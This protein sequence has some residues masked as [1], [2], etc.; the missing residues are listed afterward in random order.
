MNLGFRR[1]EDKNWEVWILGSS[2]QSVQV[3]IVSDAGWFRPAAG[4]TFHACSMGGIYHHTLLCGGNKI[5]NDIKV[6]KLETAIPSGAVCSIL[7]L[8]EFET[9]GEGF[10][11]P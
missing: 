8:K 3:G 10:Y 4:H 11:R 6:V 2:K 1:L 7:M 9:D 5:P